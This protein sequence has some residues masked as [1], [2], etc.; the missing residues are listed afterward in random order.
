ME[1]FQKVGGRCEPIA[2]ADELTVKKPQGN[3]RT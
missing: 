1:D 2:K 3:V